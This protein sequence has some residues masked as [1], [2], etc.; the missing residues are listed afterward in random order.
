[1]FLKIYSK[2]CGY[3]KEIEPICTELEQEIKNV[4]FVEMIGPDHQDFLTQYKVTHFPTLTL[5]HKYLDLPII[6]YGPR[7]KKSLEAWINF[8]T[9]F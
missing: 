2:D 5:F 3:C 6:H 7:D 1:M 9:T 8:V 4:T